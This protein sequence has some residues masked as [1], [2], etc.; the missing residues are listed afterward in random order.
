LHS[1]LPFVIKGVPQILILGPIAFLV[2]AAL[3]A[4]LDIKG[5][6]RFFKR[7]KRK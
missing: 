4:L 2:M 7:K 3:Y 5:A 1:G 6:A